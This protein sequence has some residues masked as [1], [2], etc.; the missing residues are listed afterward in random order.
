ME[1][2]MFPRKLVVGA[3][4]VFLIWN[5]EAAPQTER[6]DFD[7]NGKVDFDDFF[8]FAEAFN[9]GE[10]RFDLNGNGKVDLDDFFLFASDFTAENPPTESNSDPEWMRVTATNPG[11]SARFDHTLVHD[12]VRDLLVVF[13]GRTT[14][15]LGDTWIF[16][17]SSS[18]WREVQTTPSPAPRHG[19]TAIYDAPRMRIVIFGGQSPSGFFND[20][21]AFDSEGETWE[22]LTVSG[23]SPSTRYG[24]SAIFDAPRERMI[25]SHG[26]TSQGRFDDTWAFDLTLNRWSDITPASGSKPLKRC[27]HEAVYDATNDRML[28]FG[29]CSSGFGPCPQGDLWGLDLKADI[30][31]ELTP[32]G[33]SPASRSNPGLVYDTGGKRAL[34]FGGGNTDDDTW[35]FDVSSGNWEKLI[36]QGATPSPRRSHDMTIDPENGRLFMFGGTGST[37]ITDDLWE[38]KF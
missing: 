30:W 20:V 12:P 32:S 38:L 34:L 10:E 23:D 14:G 37:G 16:D 27:L 33:E 17:L 13:G 11:P 3:I 5:I 4:V 7:G 36:F 19:Y 18:S 2:T 28:L 21:W 9:T 1:M 6:S 25:I 31:S 29:G 15:S 22:E 8:L 35:S 26:F 24:T